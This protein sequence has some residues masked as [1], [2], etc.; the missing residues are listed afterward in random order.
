VLLRS[1][2]RTATILGVAVFVAAPIPAE[3]LTNSQAHGYA[4]CVDWCNAHNKTNNSFFQCINQC[5]KY[6][7]IPLTSTSIN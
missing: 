6:W 3:A 2:L 5:A 1:I 4:K 7:K